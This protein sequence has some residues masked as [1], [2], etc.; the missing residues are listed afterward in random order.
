MDTNGM[1]VQVGSGYPVGQLAKAFVT[2]VTHE[3]PATRDRAQSAPDGGR[4]CWL[5]W[6]PAS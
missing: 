1:D 6:R 5:A 4:L 3:D 2:A